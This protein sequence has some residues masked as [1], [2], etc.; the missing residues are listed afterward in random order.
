MIGRIGGLVGAVFGQCCSGHHSTANLRHSGRRRT[1]GVTG[2]GQHRAAGHNDK[3]VRDMAGMNSVNLRSTAHPPPDGPT[4]G[5]PCRRHWCNLV[6]LLV[7]CCSNLQ[8]A[9]D[10]R[11]R[12][13][14]HVAGRI[15]NGRRWAVPSQYT[16]VLGIRVCA[17]A[18]SAAGHGGAAD[19]RNSGQ[20]VD[21]R[22]RFPAGASDS[23]RTGAITE[24]HTVGA[25]IIWIV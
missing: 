24:E 6:S 4:Q 3:C 9:A 8:P 10:H 7:Q 21:L 17:R 11:R 2:S 15:G 14:G 1:T 13:R 23:G 22:R 5:F 20:G 19:R 16:T 12:G 25:I 18:G